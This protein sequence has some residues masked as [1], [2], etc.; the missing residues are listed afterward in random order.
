MES[1]RSTKLASFGEE[2]KKG[3]KSE[4]NRRKGPFRQFQKLSEPILRAK[5]GI[6]ANFQ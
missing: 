6:V 2:K 3:E 4:E 5:E 1:K